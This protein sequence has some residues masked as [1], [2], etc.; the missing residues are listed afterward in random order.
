MLDRL[1][2][3]G[4]TSTLVLV[5]LML[6]ACGAVRMNPPLAEFVPKFDPIAI[7]GLWRID[8][9][10]GVYRIEAGRIWITETL[11]VGP[12]RNDPG[13]VVVESLRP[14]GLLAYEGRDLSLAGA[15][16]A[17]VTEMGLDVHVSSVVPTDLEMI[18][19]ELAEIRKTGHEG[20]DFLVIRADG[21]R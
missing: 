14:R 19:I 6:T 8:T 20:G 4:R 13:Q 12:V 16:Q 9:N 11:V 3:T 7:D 21:S 18:P 15:W 5:L 2:A 10:G 17:V 1:P